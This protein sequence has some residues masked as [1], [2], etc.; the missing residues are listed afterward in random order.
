MSEE[1]IPE[2]VAYFEQPIPR[3]RPPKSLARLSREIW[4]M[5]YVAV[6]MLLGALAAVVIAEDPTLEGLVSLLGLLVVAVPLV[7]IGW[8][9]RRRNEGLFRQGRRVE[10]VVVERVATTISGR[11]RT[12]PAQGLVFAEAGGRR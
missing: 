12:F 4:I 8:A 7:V 9:I 3:G 2:V 1:L 5:Y 6:G 10:A 11:Y